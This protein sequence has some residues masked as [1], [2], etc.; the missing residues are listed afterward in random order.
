MSYDLRDI[1]NDWIADMNSGDFTPDLRK[2]FWGDD[3][4]YG[5]LGF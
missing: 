3:G 4:V 1:I 5:V 2:I